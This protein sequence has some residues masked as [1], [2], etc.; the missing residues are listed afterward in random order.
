MKFLSLISI[1][2]LSVSCEKHYH[3]G[4]YLMGFD[5]TE[6]A[7]N[8][9]IKVQ[10]GEI[11]NYRYSW[12][13]V[14]SSEIKYECKQFPDQ[15]EY[16]EDGLTKVMK[17]QNQ[18]LKVAD[19]TVFLKFADL[20]DTF[21]VNETKPKPLIRLHEKKIKIFP[22]QSNDGHIIPNSIKIKNL[23]EGL[24]YQC[25]NHISANSREPFFQGVKSFSGYGDN[26][27]KIQIE[28]DDILIT[29]SANGSNSVF[30]GKIKDGRIFDVSGS[31]SKFIYKGGALYRKEKPNEYIIFFPIAN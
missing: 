31:E 20:K 17:M 30:K 11:Y 26:I 12:D 15:I 19:N 2:L 4:V 7:T 21:F 16:V 27:Y 18:S 6:S 1:C 28:R 3:D 29:K 23:N 24:S 10:G 25:V 14:F 22:E 9:I 8:E 13:G 5:F